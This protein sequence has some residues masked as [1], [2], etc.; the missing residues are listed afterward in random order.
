MMVRTLAAAFAVFAT[1]AAAHEWTP[2]YPKLKKSIYD[3]VCVTTMTLFNRR[4]DASFYEI[5]VYNADWEPIPFATPE[6]VFRV[7]YLERKTVEVYVREND[8]PS[9]AYIC[10]T[11]KLLSEDVQSTGISSRICSKIKH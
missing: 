1:T 5:D 3:A 4:N 9:A 10:S 8:A 11:S 7:D 2:T 6:K